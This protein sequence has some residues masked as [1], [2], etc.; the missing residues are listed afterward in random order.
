MSSTIAAGDPPTRPDAAPGQVRPER[1][2][3]PV[4]AV[5]ATI[6]V[7]VAG[8]FVVAASLSEPDRSSVSIPGVVSVQ[9]LSGWRVAGSGMIGDAPPRR[10][11]Q[12]TRGSGDLSVVDWGPVTGD[13]TSL[14][15][16]VDGVLRA[17]FAQL[18]V[19][20]TLTSIVS[21]DGLHGQRFTFVGVDPTSGASVE[22]EVSTF[23]DAGG[24]GVV[25]IALAPEGLLAYVDDDLHTMIDRAQVR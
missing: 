8:G 23:T 1:R 2:W 6:L 7:V 11:V 22:G 17:S 21:E 18:S 12:L 3:L 14:A 20:N 13:A 4:L 10:Y 15:D 24:R 16:A 19:S 25:F 9:P 5:L